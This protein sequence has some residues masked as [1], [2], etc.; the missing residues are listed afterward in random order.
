MCILH[1]VIP[2]IMIANAGQ[3][4]VLGLDGPPAEPEPSSGYESVTVLSKQF[5]I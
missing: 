3:N 4:H 2:R 5:R 1:L